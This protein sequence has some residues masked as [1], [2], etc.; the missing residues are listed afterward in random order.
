MQQKLALYV[1]LACLSLLSAGA[2]EREATP[3]VVNPVLRSPLRPTLSLDGAWEFVTDPAGVGEEQQCFKPDHGLPDKISITVPGCWEAQ[4]VGGLG[5]STSVAP[6]RS[7]RPL[8]G[9][10][11]GTAWYRKETTVPKEWAGKELWL[12]IGGVDAQGWFWVNGTYQ[13]GRAHV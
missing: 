11:V 3:A 8:R 10:Y 7:I 1:G 6:E 12:K 2:Q 13:I 9:S 4:G 5:N